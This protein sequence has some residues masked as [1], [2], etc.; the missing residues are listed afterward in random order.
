MTDRMAPGHVYQPKLGTGIQWK[1]G[2]VALWEG[3]K[4]VDTAKH[5]IGSAYEYWHSLA[6]AESFPGVTHWW[7]RSGWTQRVRLSGI[8]GTI[9]GGTVWGYMQFIK[10]LPA[11]IWSIT[12]GERRDI[13]SVSP[14]RSATCEPAAAPG[15]V[16]LS[17]WG[18]LQPGAARHL[19]GAHQPGPTRGAAP[20]IP[21]Y[22]R[23]AALAA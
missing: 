20:G 18:D 22:A 12:E 8:Q 9:G 16:A 19:D 2:E 6:F 11:H 14:K 15:T 13:Y 17:D 10:G 1:P 21:G 4:I 7:F 5:T 3:G 23:S